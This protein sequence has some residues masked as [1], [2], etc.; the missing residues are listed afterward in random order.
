VSSTWPAGILRGILRRPSPLETTGSDFPSDLRHT[1]THEYLKRT[2]E[3]GVYLVGI[4]QSGQ[5]EL[6]GILSIEVGMKGEFL[7]AGAASGEIAAVKTTVELYS[8][9]R[10]EVVDVDEALE[11]KP[12]LVNED[13]YGGGWI[14]RVKVADAGTVGAFMDA[15]AH[16]AQ[17][18][19]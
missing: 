11:G 1:E 18:E 15:E 7:D 5:D 4:T 10:G 13:P 3:D 12:S 9:V 16:E 19:G 8:P 17:V 6:G 14:I 2:D